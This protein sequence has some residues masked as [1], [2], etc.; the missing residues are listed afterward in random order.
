M[1]KDA[2]IRRETNSIEDRLYDVHA[3]VTV[4][5]NALEDECVQLGARNSLADP[6]RVLDV[7]LAKLI[8]AIEDVDDLPRHAH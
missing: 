2:K 1:G 6:T 3:L 7:A 4:V 5:R 8:H